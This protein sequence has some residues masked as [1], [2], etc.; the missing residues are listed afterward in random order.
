MRL[1]IYIYTA[2]IHHFTHLLKPF[3]SDFSLDSGHLFISSLRYF[4]IFSPKQEKNLVKMSTMATLL[5]GHL[6]ETLSNEFSGI[7]NEGVEATEKKSLKKKFVEVFL[8]TKDFHTLQGK[9]KSV[10]AKMRIAF[11]KKVYFGV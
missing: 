3:H 4:P 7:L 10:S 11:M 5:F 2:W 8:E 1:Y 9:L 6:P